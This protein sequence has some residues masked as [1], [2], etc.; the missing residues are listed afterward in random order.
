[1]SELS[2]DETVTP[3]ISRKY[4]IPI[5]QERI[6]KYQEQVRIEIQKIMDNAVYLIVD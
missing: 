5:S 1:M 6:H 2:A 4:Q 3:E